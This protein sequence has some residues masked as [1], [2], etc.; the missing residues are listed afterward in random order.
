[1]E[2]NKISRRMFLAGTAAASMVGCATARKPSLRRLG[3]RS[4]NEKLNV[5]GIGVGGKG[6]GDI[7]GCKSENIV[8][9]CDVD[10]GRA[11]DSFRDFPQAKRY[12]DFREMLEKEDK[13]IDAVTISTPDHVHAVAA[14]MAMKMGKHVYVQK[15]LTHS[16]YEARKLTEAARKY[17]VATQMG[18]QGHS[19]EGVRRFCEMIWSGTI[20]EVREVHAWTNRP[21]WPQ[22]IPEP[23]PEQPVPEDKDID[24]DLWLGPAPWRP[25]NSDYAPFKWRGWWD[26]GTG[27]LGDMACHIMD[28]VN[29]AMM[30]GYPSSVE[31]LSQEGKNDQTAP[32]KSIIRYEFPARG[33]MPP[34]T[35]TWYD[36]GN[37]PPRPEGIGENVR[38]G[39]GDNGSLFIGERGMIAIGTYGG[40]PRLFPESLRADYETPDPM[41]P[42]SIGHYREWIQACKGGA[43]SPGNF[44]Y[45]GPFTEWVVMGN[46]ALRCEGKLLWDGEK[47]KVTN[48]RGANRYVRRKYRKGWKL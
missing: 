23:L 31:C 40:S 1:M 30:L 44:D 15:P 4:P 27:A 24:W 19:G 6:G 2:R 20:G 16:V 3:Y 34:V 29:W 12:R 5:A 28:P 17:G 42:R 18:N 45:A 35:V 37:L 36:G 10:W 22:G 14:M 38:L 13:N 21:I 33:G 48:N 46:L 47:M 39:D 7:D 8:V 41:I 26:F 9:L 43:P 25:Y 32:N 11:R